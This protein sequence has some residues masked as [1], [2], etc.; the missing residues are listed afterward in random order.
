MLVIIRTYILCFFNNLLTWVPTFLFLF[1][2]STMRLRYFYS[3]SSHCYLWAQDM[4]TTL[5]IS[6]EQVMPCGSLG[7]GSKFPEPYMVRKTLRMWANEGFSDCPVL[8]RRPN[9]IVMT[10]PGK[11]RSVY[12]RCTH[13]WEFNQITEMYTSA[14]NAE[15]V[16]N[17]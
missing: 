10:I 11:S 7:N 13:G 4:T 14:Q 16:F 5:T 12:P 2:F 15:E 6:I 1:I 8:S 17:N 9:I 3:G